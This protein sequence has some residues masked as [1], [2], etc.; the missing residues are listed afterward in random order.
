MGLHRLFWVPEGMSARD[1]VYVR[2]PHE[3]L[4]AILL[5]EA[6]LAGAV[7]VGEDLGTVPRRVRTTMRRHGLHRSYVLQYEVRDDPA[8]ALPD[9]RPESF[10]SL[11]T[12]DMPT[13]RSF[14]EGADIDLRLS[15]GLLDRAGAGDERRA[16]GRTRKALVGFLRRRG[17]FGRRPTGQG[18]RVEPGAGQVLRAALRHLARSDARTMIVG[19]EDLWGEAAPQNVPGTPTVYGNWSRKARLGLESFRERRGVLDTLGEVDRLRNEGGA[20]R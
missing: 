1:G 16:R 18:R 13:F 9:P 19:L 2:Y 14:F 6:H 10:A 12:H 17:R 3:E 11:N 8:A 20:D 7:V 4:Y 5:L 15:L